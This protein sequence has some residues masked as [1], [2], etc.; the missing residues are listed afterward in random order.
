[1]NHEGWEAHVVNSSV[2]ENNASDFEWNGVKIIQCPR[3]FSEM[4]TWINHNQYDVF[5]FAA[6]IREALKDL[7]GLSLMKCKKIVIAIPGNCAIIL[8]CEKEGAGI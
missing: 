5:C 1:M 7:S 6:T 2:S 8:F 3:I 4:S